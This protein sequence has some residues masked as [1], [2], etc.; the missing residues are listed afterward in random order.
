MASSVQLDYGYTRA[1]VEP[2]E[3]EARFEFT[4]H[5]LENEFVCG[6]VHQQ[7]QEIGPIEIKSYIEL[8]QLRNCTVIE[9]SLKIASLKEDISEASF[10][11]LVEI[12]GYL[13]IYRVQGRKQICNV[14]FAALE[15]HSM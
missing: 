9:G 6:G 10:P 11:K 13:I 2:S 7:G 12:T 1:D 4:E 5:H 3:H 15:R 8:V 14:A